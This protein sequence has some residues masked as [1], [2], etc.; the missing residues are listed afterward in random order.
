MHPVQTKAR[1]LTLLILGTPVTHVARICHVP[2]Q[3]VSR[4]RV[5]VDELLFDYYREHQHYPL[6][7]GN[8]DICSTIFT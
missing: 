7:G 1:A 5:E 4:W 8:W 2:K 6:L 3:T